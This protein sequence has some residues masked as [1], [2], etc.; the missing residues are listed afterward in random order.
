LRR[1]EALVDLKTNP[2]LKLRGL[3][4]LTLA[5]PGIGSS[6][7]EQSISTN[8]LVQHIASQFGVGRINGTL[9]SE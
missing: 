5:V 6:L 4:R 2:P 3:N 8:Q 9:A 1:V 7:P